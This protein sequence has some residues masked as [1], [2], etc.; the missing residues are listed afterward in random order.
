MN[1]NLA[2]VLVAQAM[3]AISFGLGSLSVRHLLQQVIGSPQIL[4]S[5]SMESATHNVSAG[6]RNQFEMFK[7][8]HF[9]TYLRYLRF[10]SAL[11]M[12]CSIFGTFWA[13]Q[14]LI[15]NTGG[16]TSD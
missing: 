8:N 12:F 16:V 1:I 3:M 11:E 5:W 2:Y 4:M 7:D 6:S 14:A 9:R 10:I 15:F 13:V